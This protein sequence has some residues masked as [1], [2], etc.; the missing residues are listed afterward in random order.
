[1]SGGRPRVRPKPTDLGILEAICD[2][3]AAGEAIRNICKDEAMPR[4]A[5][6]YVE[7]YRNEAF[8]NG[9]ARAREAQQEHE[10][11]FMVEVADEAT[12]ENVQVAKLRIWA[13]Q[14][15]AAKLAPKRYG[16]K[17]TVENT[18]ADGGPIQSIGINTTD[19]IEAAKIY[20]R[21]IGGK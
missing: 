14:W 9:I 1:M 19:P 17:T 2:R 6:I 12:P 13:R 11:D 15:R 20:Q 16:D 4:A 18:G 7:M 10:A 21:L 5:E 3:L 8:R